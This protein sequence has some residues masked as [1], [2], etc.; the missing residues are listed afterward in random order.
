M[1]QACNVKIY[2]FRKC[3]LVQN[4]FSEI[5]NVCSMLKL[6]PSPVINYNIA[7]SWER[8]SIYMDDCR[9]L[10]FSIFH[11]FLYFNLDII[12]L[13]V[14]CNAC[15]SDVFLKI[16][17]RMWTMPEAKEMIRTTGTEEN[18]MKLLAG[19]CNLKTVSIST[20]LSFSIAIIL[21]ITNLLLPIQLI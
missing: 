3:I 16:A 4:E 6:L 15:N 8:N 17:N 18:K 2:I 9:A 13:S 12:N 19:D 14:A 5:L 21:S 10:Y 20:F 11:R 7:F 1:L